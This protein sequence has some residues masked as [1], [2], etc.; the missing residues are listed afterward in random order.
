MKEK[1]Q[2]KCEICDATFALKQHL[3][4]HISTVHERKRVFKCNIC[5]KSFTQNCVRNHIA[6]VHEKVKPFKCDVCDLTFS[7]KTQN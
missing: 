3:K 5:D 4:G 6:M 2:E 7:I 1:K